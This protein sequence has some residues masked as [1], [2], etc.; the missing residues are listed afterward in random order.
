MECHPR[1]KL[2]RNGLQVYKRHDRVKWEIHHNTML[3]RGKYNLRQIE[4]RSCRN[5]GTKMCFT[6]FQITAWKKQ[7]RIQEKL[8]LS[9]CVD[10]SFKTLVKNKWTNYQAS[11][12]MRQVLDVT[13]H[14]SHVTNTPTATATDPPHANSLRMLLLIVTSTHHKFVAQF[15]CC[16]I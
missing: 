4:C 1:E 15:A 11:C 12:V 8:N 9:T 6:S 2:N 16:W 13:C 14:L 7:I 3:N 10:S 5:S